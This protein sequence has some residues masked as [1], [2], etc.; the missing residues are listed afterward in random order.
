[1]IQHV[2]EPPFISRVPQPNQA[3]PTSEVC[4]H[5]SE[6][7]AQQSTSGYQDL[8][9]QTIQLCKDS[10]K[11]MQETVTAAMGLG[12]QQV[13]KTTVNTLTTAMNKMYTAYSGISPLPST[14][15]TTSSSMPA[16]TTR[17]HHQQGQYGI[18]PSS[19]QNTDLIS[20]EIRENILSGKNVWYEPSRT[21]R[22]KLL[23]LIPPT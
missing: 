21:R 3:T 11:T 14:C 22:L 20:Q 10:M 17:V 18:V 2:Q 7:S 1:M 8:M 15:T 5:Q 4:A 13:A 12:L 16:V 19:V 23:S 9:F 6:S